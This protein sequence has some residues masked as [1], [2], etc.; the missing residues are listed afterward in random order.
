MVNNGLEIEKFIGVYGMFT[1]NVAAINL[2]RIVVELTDVDQAHEDDGIFDQIISSLTP[3]TALQTSGWETYRNEEFKF[4]V[5]Y[6]KDWTL[7]AHR[8]EGGGWYVGVNTPKLITTPA[9][10][11][12]F[13]FP[14]ESLDNWYAFT[15][16]TRQAESP[17]LMPKK[18]NTT[19]GG[20]PAFRIVDPVSEGGCDSVY[21]AVFFDDNVYRIQDP[22]CS[23]NPVVSEIASSFKFIR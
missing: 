6:P 21:L 12:I 23:S 20:L 14:A 2:G 13:I 17:E 10:F 5:Q 22:S 16:R 15:F 9:D 3:T 1:S 18:E 8:V 19:V 11:W 7:D 4:Q